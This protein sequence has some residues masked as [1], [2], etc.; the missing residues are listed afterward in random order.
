MT[1][2]A[3]KCCI[4]TTKNWWIQ[5]ECISLI[6]AIWIVKDILERLNLETEEDDSR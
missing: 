1:V 4:Y 2:T 3:R 6:E 5:G